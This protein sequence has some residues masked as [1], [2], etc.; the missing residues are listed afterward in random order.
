MKIKFVGPKAIISHTGIVFDKNKEDK[1]V[2]L[3]IVVQLLKALDHEYIEDKMYNYNAETRRL[4]D[5]ELV[6]ELKNY[7]EDME[8]IYTDTKMSAEKYV[9][10]QIQHAKNNTLLNSQEREILL[11]NINLMRK[12]IIQRSINK[13]L[14][15]CAIDTLANIMKR[16]HIDYV[17]APMF[18]K[19][20]HVFHSVE[21]ILHKGKNP[22]DTDLEIFEQNGNLLV[23]LDIIHR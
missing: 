12:Y 17:I 6:D 11:K 2:Y 3:N 23:K 13:S 19:F 21:G 8:Q 20:A 22:I 18:Q 1:Y 16:G 14:Y 4:S 5:N 10:N 15:Y 7:C 9:D